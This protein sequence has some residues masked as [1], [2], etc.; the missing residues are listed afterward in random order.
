MNYRDFLQKV[1]YHVINPLISALIKLHI[2][3]NIIT[4]VGLLLNLLATAL[5]IYAAVYAPQQLNL[6]GWG[7][8]V[9]LFAGLFDMIDGRLARVGGMQ[10][11]FGALLDSTLDR[12][13]ELFTLFG[14]AIYLL[15][16]GYVWSGVI[17]F[18]AMVGSVMVSYVR[19]RAEGLAI[20]CK[21]GFMQRPERV[22]VTSVGA[23]LCGCCADCVSF[24]P[25]WLLIVPMYLIAILANITAFWRIAHCYRV[26]NERDHQKA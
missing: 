26:L 16:N 4:F 20:E 2:T 23:L 25:L 14:I 22:V 9:I 24:D 7:G 13:S 17:T 3:P 21:V 5:F 1:I 10:S 19:A 12:Y 11:T 8:A 18:A 6:I 15:L